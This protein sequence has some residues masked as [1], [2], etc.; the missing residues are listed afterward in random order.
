M[1]DRG[2]GAPGR[3][4]ECTCNTGGSDTAFVARV[5]WVSATFRNGGDLLERLKRSVCPDGMWRQVP[6]ISGYRWGERCGHVVIYYCGN[7]NTVS[8]RLSGSACEQLALDCGVRDEA[9]WQ[10]FFRRLDRLG[11]RFKRVDF[12]LDDKTG[13]LT[14]PRLIRKAQRC[15]L[16]SRFRRAREIKE[17]C[18]KSRK[19]TGLTLIFGQPGNSDYQVR[20]YDKH[21]QT[22]GKASSAEGHWLRVEV[23][24]DDDHAQALVKAFVSQGFKAV[25]DDVAA[26]LSFRSPQRHDSNKSRW[27]LYRPWARF[28]GSTPTLIPVGEI[29]VTASER[30]SRL[31][32]QH[33]RHLQELIDHPDRFSAVLRAAGE[34]SSHHVAQSRAVPLPPTGIAAHARARYEMYRQ[35]RSERAPLHISSRTATKQECRRPQRLAELATD[36]VE[37]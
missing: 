26:R 32:R 20:F 30:D 33:F 28:V 11:A 17:W 4:G 25:S 16:V 7:D 12:A 22:T 34:L 2:N 19:K 8:L 6:G 24:A 27:P 21:L 13:L 15:E 5:D 35:I 36:C 29:M 1:R 37:R 10:Q 14:L 3:G 23:Q 9:A 31:V 18:L